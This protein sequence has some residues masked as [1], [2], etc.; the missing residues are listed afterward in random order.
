[1]GAW[2][3]LAVAIA[4]EVTATSFLKLSDGFAKWH[5]GVASILLYSACFWVFAPALK[6]IPIGVAYA[7]W[8]GVGIVAVAAIGTVA[9]GQKLGLAQLLFVAMVL[10]GAVGLRV[11]SSEEGPARPQPVEAPTSS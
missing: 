4:L 11:T 2:T 1:M 9:F 10:V 6:T 3:L 5:W 7:V 8:A